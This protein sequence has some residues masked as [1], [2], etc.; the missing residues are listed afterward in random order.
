VVASFRLSPDELGG[1]CATDARNYNRFRFTQIIMEYIPSVPVSWAGDP[2]AA[3]A[4]TT[5]AQNFVLGYSSDGAADAVSTIDYS[6]AQNVADNSVIPVWTCGGLVVKNLGRDLYY[7]ETD[8]TTT[9][10]RRA[11]NQGLFL[12]RWNTL[13]IGTS[14]VAHNR[15][16]GEL[17]IHY[18]LDLYDRAS[19]YGFTITFNPDLK[20]EKEMLIFLF[21]KFGSKLHRR[22]LVRLK[23]LLSP[24]T[25]STQGIDDEIKVL[26]PPF[27]DFVVIEEKEE[28]KVDLSKL[29][30]TRR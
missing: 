5:G 14:A 1:Q 27:N 9:A 11:T 16:V 30:S 22:S 29:L 15:I 19:D 7:S 25:S 3:E 20:L 18:V 6:S 26:L 4:V 17:V 13:P 12:G 21:Q 2:A 23:T 10:G 8:L 28:K 24:D